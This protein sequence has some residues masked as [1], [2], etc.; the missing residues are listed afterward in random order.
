MKDGQ[1]E[2]EGQLQR[3]RDLLREFPQGPTNATIRDLI[4]ELEQ[5][6][7]ALEK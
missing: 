7:R 2:L 6:L 4:E 3:Y 5:K 1:R